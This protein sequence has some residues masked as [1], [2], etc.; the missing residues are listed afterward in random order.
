[1]GTEVVLP[2]IGFAMNDAALSQWLVADGAEV[3]EGEPLFAIESDKSIE[4]I[5]SP[6]SGTLK[7]IAKPG[8][9]YAVGVVLAEIV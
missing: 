6:A 7:I 5:P 2:T 9:T 4:E 8:E 3:R 1:M